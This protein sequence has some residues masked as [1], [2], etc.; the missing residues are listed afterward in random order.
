MKSCGSA[1]AIRSPANT[2]RSS[3]WKTTPSTNAGRSNVTT[4]RASSAIARLNRPCANSS[5]NSAAKQPGNWALRGRSRQPTKASS[6]RAS[7]TQHFDAAAYRHAPMGFNKE[8]ESE[9]V[10]D[11]PALPASG[12]TDRT[13]AL[14]LDSNAT[15]AGG[16]APATL[17]QEQASMPPQG[18][19]AATPSAGKPSPDGPATSAGED[20]KQPAHG[21]GATGGGAIDPL[22]ALAAAALAGLGWAGRRKRR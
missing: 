1:K 19:M 7:G 4:P 2:P 9:A 11:G 10:A 12:S 21:G 17:P 13:D 14:A 3:C 16:S 15:P 5:H 18:P 22:T 20:T 6:R 8:K